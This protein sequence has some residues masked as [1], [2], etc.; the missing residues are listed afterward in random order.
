[1]PGKEALLQDWDLGYGPI[2]RR[3]GIYK[4]IRHL[5]FRHLKCVAT[6]G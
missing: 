2:N 5:G 4:I 1:L 3:L 6:S